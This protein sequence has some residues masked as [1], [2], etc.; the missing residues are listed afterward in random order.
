MINIKKE[1]LLDSSLLNK[2]NEIE[3]SLLNFYL[4]ENKKLKFKN[5][6]DYYKIKNKDILSNT[7]LIKN[8]LK[9]PLN[10]L[11]LKINEDGPFNLISSS[12]RNTYTK[13]T[14]ISQNSNFNIYSIG[15]LKPNETLNIK[16]NTIL[17]IENYNSYFN[18][19]FHSIDDINN[20][21]NSMKLKLEQPMLSIVTKPKEDKIEIENIGSA[22]STNIIYRYEFPKN[23]IIDAKSIRYDLKGLVCSISFKIVN[24]NILF[25]ISNI[26][27]RKK[28]IIYLK[29][30]N[31]NSLLSPGSMD[32]KL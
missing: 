21:L 30:I 17:N 26:P 22:P 28:I 20:E 13:E 8:T 29:H 27:D 4:E 23:Y 11:K 9:A 16:F 15:S 19:R 7:L 2:N 32:L 10:N 14:Y 12:L 3:L 18:R 24:N 6:N 5:S 25:N 31:V 1:I